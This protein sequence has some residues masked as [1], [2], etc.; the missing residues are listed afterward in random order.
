[1]PTSLI[2]LVRRCPLVVDSVKIQGGTRMVLWNLAMVVDEK[3]EATMSRLDIHRETGR[4]LVSVDRAIGNLKR[5]GLL[6]ARKAHRKNIWILNREKLL[7]LVKTEPQHPTPLQKM[8]S[9]SAQESVA[10]P[11]P[12]PTPKLK[13]VHGVEDAV[14]YARLE[15]SCII[16]SLWFSGS[17]DTAL[18]KV[19]SQIQNIDPSLQVEP[20]GK[21]YLRISGRS[22][23]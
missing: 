10:T 13:E 15:G 2:N 7:D 12:G 17:Q 21:D 20:H 5:S 3:D 23:E 18:N 14:N 6:R 16:F 8:P 22:T 19:R 11:T 1:M 4:S 9:R